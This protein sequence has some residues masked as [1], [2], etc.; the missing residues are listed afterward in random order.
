MCL[1]F[2]LSLISLKRI[3]ALG[4]VLLL[5]STIAYPKPRKKLTRMEAARLAA[6]FIA[7]NGYT[8]L[9]PTKDKS[10]LTF[11]HIEWQSTVD[12]V[13]KDRHNTLE[14][15]AYGVLRGSRL[16]DGWT[17]PSAIRIRATKAKLFAAAPSRWMI[18]GTTC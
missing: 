3:L 2:D 1:T 17:V 14:R 5:I 15:K 6:T 12:E 9:P 18:T 13:L 16:K 4:C 10:K 8:D 7:Q 11:E